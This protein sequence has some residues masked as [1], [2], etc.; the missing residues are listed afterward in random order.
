MYL[1]KYY[2]W[3]QYFSNQSIIY[4]IN[5]LINSGSIIQNS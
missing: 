5:Y 2:L 4:Q 3:Y 1:N